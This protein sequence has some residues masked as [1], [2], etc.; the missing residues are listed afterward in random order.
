MTNVE[1]TGA[2]MRAR[3]TDLAALGFVLAGLGSLL[4]VIAVL[5]WEL[6]TEGEAGFF[7]IPVAVAAIAVFVIRRPAT[8]GKV[9]GILLALIIAFFLWWTIFGLF[10]GP[11]NFF[12]FLPGVLVLPGALT[13]LVASIAALVAGRRGH[14]R[15]A[16]EGGERT[17]MRIAVLI[18]VLATVVSG[19]LTATSRSTVADASAATATV[20]MKDFEFAPA[21]ISVAG[22]S[23]ILVRNDDP[24][25]HTFTVDALSIDETTTLGSEKLITIPSRPGTYILYCKPHTSDPDDPSKDDMAGT[26]VVT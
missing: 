15:A 18:V 4:L 3:W 19:I 2:R 17:G 21:E 10:T 11:L 25:F 14:L 16:A 6:N 5:G 1:S 24:F 26:L 13:A 9:V 8:W 7:A 12:D 20:V 23:S 22:G